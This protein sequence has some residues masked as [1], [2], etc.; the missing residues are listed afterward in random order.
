MIQY[1]M[2]FKTEQSNYFYT[3]IELLNTIYQLI[4]SFWLTRIELEQNA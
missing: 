1:R 3:K 4:L 2:H